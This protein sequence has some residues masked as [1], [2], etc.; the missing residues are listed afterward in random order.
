MAMTRNQ[1]TI[2]KPLLI[3]VAGPTASG[4]TRLSIQLAQ[5]F[6]TE[7]ISADSR[8]FYREMKIGTAAPTT[9]EQ[10]GIPHHFIGHLSI[11][12]P[13]NVSMFESEVIAL[14]AD[15]FKQHPVVIMT[16]GS[17][18]YI[19]AVCR[20]ID[21]LPDPDPQLRQQLKNQLSEKGI[22][23]LQT[24][25]KQLDPPGYD[26]I[27][28]CN[29]SRLIRALEVTITTGIP[30]SSL[31]KQTPRQRPF[32]VLKTALTLPKEILHHR[33]HQRVDSMLDA[34]WIREAETL[35][36][37]SHLNALNTVGYKELFSYLK[38][39]CS[40]SEAVEKI[41]TNTRRYAKRQMTWFR[42][43]DAIQWF[44]PED[45]QGI[46]K[47]VPSAFFS[48]LSGNGIEANPPSDLS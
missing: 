8:Q 6:G 3:V 38:G 45:L 26:Q 13:Y 20:G 48:R 19:D 36:P 7:I 9:R 2:E 41:K 15:L 11:R 37:F 46:I 33:I 43:D 28:I 1:M 35:L 27:D 32:T 42:K 4:K 21:D 25:L 17:G 29:P 40:L 44:D 34:G 24:Y 47:K 10:E 22:N 16:G 31:R 14:L 5:H 23:A 30:Y 12:D 39:E 18:L